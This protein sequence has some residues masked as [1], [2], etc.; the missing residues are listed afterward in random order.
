MTPYLVPLFCGL[1]GPNSGVK[2]HLRCHAVP[3]YPNGQT[4]MTREACPM[5]ARADTV[6]AQIKLRLRE[7]LRAR[8]ETEAKQNG[9]SLNTEIVRRL[10]QSIRDEE[11]G[12]V[13]FG[14]RDVFNSAYII[15]GLIRAFEVH[16][17][18]KLREDLSI[19]GMA[20]EAAKRFGSLAGIS[21]PLVTGR[22]VGDPGDIF[23]FA[24]Q[25]LYAR[26]TETPPQDDNDA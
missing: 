15:A 17:G 4:S 21:H 5:A 2:D 6:K 7:P 8:L 9:Y 11:L 12:D 23:D 20:L 25:T 1:Y 26:A 19:F 10:E 14:D 13:I 18:K 22:A 3:C 16:T 24:A